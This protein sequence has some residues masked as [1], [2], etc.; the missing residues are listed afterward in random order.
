MKPKIDWKNKKLLVDAANNSV[1]YA[2]MLRTLG[3]STVSSNVTTLKKHITNHNIDVSHFSGGHS[4]Q[5]IQKVDD[6][7]K[8]EESNQK[9]EI[10]TFTLT[11]SVPDFNSGM[12]IEMEWNDPFIDFLKKSGY[13]GIKADDLISDFVSQLL[14]QLAEYRQDRGDFQG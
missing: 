6:V 10:P 11:S 3:L 5:P 12:K 4:P 13:S 1:S 7:V 14:A 9:R 8:Q 2:E